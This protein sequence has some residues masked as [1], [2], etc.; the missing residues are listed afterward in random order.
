[1]PA[2]SLTRV[3]AALVNGEAV[4][5]VQLCGQTGWLPEPLPEPITVYPRVDALNE[6]RPAAALV[7][8]DRAAPG[9]S[10]DIPAVHYRPPTLVLGAGASRGIPAAELIGLAG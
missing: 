8:S 10:P 9:I 6:A 4:G 7:V 1:D 5:V 3:A 2:S